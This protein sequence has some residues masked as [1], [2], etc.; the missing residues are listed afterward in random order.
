MRLILS[1]IAVGWLPL[2]TAMAAGAVAAGQE[3]VFFAFDDQS[4]PWLDN[5]QLTLVP[6]EKHPAGPVLQ[7]GPEGSPDY[8]QAILYG[9]VQRVGEKFR[10]WYLAGPTRLSP[11]GPKPG[12]WRPMCYAESDDGVHWIKPE[13]GLVE[14]HGSRRNNICRIESPDEALTLVDDFLTVIYEPEEADPAR[15]Y[16]AAYIVHYPWDA[17]PGGVREV[18]GG[19]FKER[20]LC[21]MVC[22]ASADGLSWRVVVD[23]PCVNEKFEVSGLYHFGNFYYAAGQQI[24]PWSW[25]ADGSATGRAMSCYRSPDLVHWSSAK[26]LAF[27]RAGQTTRPPLAGQQSHMG[28]GMWNR[29]NVIVGLYGMWQDGPSPLPK[30]KHFPYGVRID[31]GLVLSNDGRH[32]R[33]PVPDFKILA[34]GSPDQW[35]CKSLLQGHAF[36]NVEERTYLWYSHWDTDGEGHPEEIG[37][38]TIRRDGFGYLACRNPGRPAHCITAAIPAA[39]GGL[40]LAVNV[41][42]VAADRPLVVE[43]LDEADR[44]LPGYSGRDAARVTRPGVRR[45]VVWPAHPDGRG[46]PDRGYAIRASLPAAAEVRLYAIY[47]LPQ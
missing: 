11:K 35:D 24:S 8:G 45:E 6:A 1:C 23:R 22:A 13:L 2:G 44:P 38:A 37:L 17:I 29:G 26:G 32:F 7:R 30:G 14:F 27:V 20:R 42:G 21:A 34:R 5:L 9:S 18:V 43:L 40:G 12:N 36:A 3:R 47:V 19:R 15:R 33:E 4:I 39:P 31:L 46:P 10:M 25:L 41:A 16:K 28:A